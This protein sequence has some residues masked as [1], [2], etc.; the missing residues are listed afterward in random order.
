MD[1]T[2]V[3]E[4]KLI[5]TPAGKQA[6]GPGWFA[7]NIADAAAVDTP[8]AGHGWLFEAAEG[9]FPH[10]GFNVQVL[11]PGEPN[12]KYHAEEGQ[13][14]F[15]VLHGEVRVIVEDEERILRQWDFFYSPPWTAHVFVGAGE[16]PSTILMVGARNAGEGL[17]YPRNE[18]A[19]RYDAS[20]E[21][22][23]ENAEE[24]YAGWTRPEPARKPWPP[25]GDRR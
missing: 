4:A 23:T 17:I 9:R 11:N 22:T 21:H 24:A 16:G 1:R 25:T 6:A 3:N 10:F 5:D 13:E 20:A 2:P 19:A 18:T 14:A 15:L 7:V 12:A 8:N